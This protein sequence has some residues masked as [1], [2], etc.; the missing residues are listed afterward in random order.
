MMI[1]MISFNAITI[2]NKN[3]RMIINLV[4]KG[5]RLR[6][7]QVTAIVEDHEGNISMTSIM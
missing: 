5:K 3:G 4:Q 2:M 1:K 7:T 6:A